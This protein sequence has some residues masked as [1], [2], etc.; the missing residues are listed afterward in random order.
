MLRFLFFRWDDGI[1]LPS[2]T[3]NVLGLSLSVAMK[4]WDPMQAGRGN[5]GVFRM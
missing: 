1:I 3:R 2:D 5:F 4:S